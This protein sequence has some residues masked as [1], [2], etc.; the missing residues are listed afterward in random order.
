MVA[1][2]AGAWIE[3]TYKK[4]IIWGI[5]VAPLAG[6]WIETDYEVWGL[7]HKHVAPLAGAW[8]ET[9]F[10]ENIKSIISGRSPRGSVD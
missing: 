2:L 6:A 4:N 7:N 8:I 9:I 5:V 10:N 3:T 1:P